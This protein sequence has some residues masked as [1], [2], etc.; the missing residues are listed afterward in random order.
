MNQDDFDFA[1][2]DLGLATGIEE[3][4]EGDDFDAF[5]DDTFGAEEVWVED[6]HEELA[7]YT[8]EEKLQ[9][10]ESDGFFDFD[11][12]PRKQNGR[13]EHHSPIHQS[14]HEI[15]ELS[16]A[17]VDKMSSRPQT[18]PM[19]DP[20]I[21]N[22]MHHPPVG[23]MPP[24]MP[25]LPPGI[26]NM[27]PPYAYMQHP[28]FAM[29]PPSDLN[30]PAIMS[31]GS[32]PPPRMMMPQHAIRPP[33]HQPT[34]MQVNVS[35]SGARTLEEI[36]RQMM[37]QP[38]ETVQH[39]K[40]PVPQHY[41]QHHQ[42][43][44]QHHPLHQ[45]QVQHPQMHH[46]LS[47]SQQ[48][49]QHQ[50]QSQHVQQNQGQSPSG[51]H[52]YNQNAQNFDK[53]G[54]R[55]QSGF[56]QP[57]SRNPFDN[58]NRET[59]GDDFVE[60][61]AFQQRRLQQ[62]NNL[63]TP[64]HVHVLG[65]LRGAR[66]RQGR[67]SNQGILTESTGNPMRDLELQRMVAA[68]RYQVED[69]F[70]QDDE[71]AGLMTQRERQWIINIQLSQLKCENP[72]LDDYYYTVF[73]LRRQQLDKS[74]DDEANT[75]GVISDSRSDDL[76]LLENEGRLP[77]RDEEG[78]QLLIQPDSPR[79]TYTPL[80][81]SNSLGKLQAATVKA[82]R[83]II[84]VG[85]LNTDSSET[86]SQKDARNYKLTLLELERL[87]NLLI[88]VEDC[89]KKLI[90]LP[91]NAPMRIHVEEE[92]DE[93]V[94]KF[95]ANLTGGN[96]LKRYLTVRKGKT[97]MKR[98]LRFLDV[99]QM[100]LVCTNLLQHFS[101][102]LRKDREEQ[103]LSD[104]WHNGLRSHLLGAPYELVLHYL[105]ILTMPSYSLKPVVTSSLGSSILLALVH[106]CARLLE[107]QD[108]FEPARDLL[109]KLGEKLS[110]CPE[111]SGPIGTF[112]IQVPI[113]NLVDECKTQLKR[114][115]ES[116]NSKSQHNKH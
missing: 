58:K 108:D 1:T 51:H 109:T 82:P 91:T 102:I 31:M 83:K 50:G 40:P 70:H 55:N 28:R 77:K 60:H 13:Q 21:V 37:S 100:G 111:M 76:T 86:P 81:F 74:P 75:F 39:Q 32:M 3:D 67:P 56:H 53:Q 66:E 42:H 98:G 105:T 38:P 90:A 61:H 7:K 59:F 62:E 104:F 112:H 65:I 48:G 27:P 107:D 9:Q 26:H 73:K 78:A 110:E 96:R 41:G 99:L 44:G 22:V 23:I 54:G 101:A 34:Q 12:M 2:A 49:H 63:I 69:H 33:F 16:Q 87:Y 19:M 14:Q 57:R 10:P 8:E 89:E 11:E 20:A 115:Q 15:D 114:L 24:P 113:C 52:R 45:H 29:P 43:Q 97:L 36:E 46:H 4:V 85:I 106:Q 92:R 116:G 5:N 93:A 25:F 47:Q 6:D 72:F 80:Q 88:E 30:D 94:K 68:R 95:G 71:Y 64:G 103:L 17:F 35:Q 79:N 18:Q 84:D